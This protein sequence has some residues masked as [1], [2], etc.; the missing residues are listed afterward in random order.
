VPRY[1]TI[2]DELRQRIDRGEIRPGEPFPT[3]MALCR[4]FGVSRHTVRRALESL[5]RSGLI[6]RR[7][8]RGTFVTRPPLVTQPLGGFYTFVGSVAGQGHQPHSLVL[9]QQIILASAAS[10]ERLR[11]ASGTP[12][13]YLV[14]KR[15]ADDV[16]LALETTEVPL[17]VC[18]DLATIELGDQSLYDVIEAFS[19]VVI[20]GAYET[21]RPTLLS[22]EEAELLAVPPNS[23][24]FNVERVTSAGQQVVEWRRSLI[25][26]DCYLYSV[27][28]P[29]RGLVGTFQAEPTSTG[30]KS[31]SIVTPI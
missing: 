18:P 28:L 9:Q 24:A 13:V 22:R 5:E 2:E 17:S 7:Q 10:A 29:R 20:S 1:A 14:R 3:E 27:D 8:G 23:P 11:I 4:D 31:H 26:G 15:L 16:P 25:R 19:D 30:E 6:Y 21:I 12:V